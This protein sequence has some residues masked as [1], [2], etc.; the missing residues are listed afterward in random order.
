V[1]VLV[2]HDEPI[3]AGYGAE[4][5]VRR[6]VTG[7]V[8]AGDQVELIAG[9]HR[10]HGLTKLFDPWDPT[11]WRMVTE[12]AHR[13]GPD[14]IHHHNIAREL[15]AS[16]LTAAP[17]IPA[18]MTVHDQ[19][20]VGAREHAPL[21]P[22]GIAESIGSAVLLR[23]ACRH[24]AATIA[25]SDRV[26]G[27]LQA[28]GLPDVITIP[29][30]ISE[31]VGPAR[32]AESCR[33][34]AVIGRL[35]PD[36][37]VDLVIDAFALL[38]DASRTSR[39]VIA[40]DGPGRATLERRAAPL[41]NQVR[42]LGRL[43]E[44]EVSALLGQV[45]VVVVASMPS[46]RPEGSSLTAAEAAGH[47]RAVIGSDDPAVVEVVGRTGAGETV[48]AGDA[49]ALA[50]ALRRYLTDDGLVAAAAARAKAGSASHSIAAVTAATRDVYRRVITS[51]PAP[52][53][54]TVETDG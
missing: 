9:E 8:A 12:R 22:R 45:R 39:L 27:L 54:Q 29:V 28:A 21:S 32:P 14:V 52:A 34:V 13:F 15:S 16:V 42:F 36:K 43:D 37:G 24:L 3:D 47:S 17:T 53:G 5:Y 48:P 7:L 35:A 18:V 33:D 23:T 44:R 1:K 26:A 46:R 50:A 40:G 41:G 19:R 51:G 25:V 10:H 2:V 11:A 49:R 20:M 38:G 31:P 30:P 4:A 6:L